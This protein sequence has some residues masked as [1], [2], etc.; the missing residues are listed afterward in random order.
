MLNRIHTG[1]VL[2]VAVGA[3]RSPTVAQGTWVDAGSALAGTSGDPHLVGTGPLVENLGITLSLTN[4]KPGAKAAMFV[5]VGS[6]PVAFHGGVLLAFPALVQVPIDVPGTGALALPATW[7]AGLPAGLELCFQYI[8]KDPAAV[9]GFALSNAVRAVTKGP[10]DKFLYVSG[11]YQ[12]DPDFGLNSNDPVQ[13]D[14]ATIASDVPGQITN[15]LAKVDSKT[16]HTLWAMHVWECG[17]TYGDA[18]NG[19]FTAVDPGTQDVYVSVHIGSATGSVVRFYDVTSASPVA[20]HATDN[21]EQCFLLKYSKDGVF[22]W[23]RWLRATPIANP[24]AASLV[25]ST[26]RNLVVLPGGNVVMAVDVRVNGGFNEPTTLMLGG[27]ANE[28]TVAGFLGTSA[29]GPFQSAVMEIDPSGAFVSAKRSEVLEPSGGCNS[30]TLIARETGSGLYVMHIQS[31]NSVRMGEG[32]AN[33]FVHLPLHPLFEGDVFFRPN[34]VKYDTTK[35]LQWCADT[36][37]LNGT[38]STDFNAA[39]A[40]LAVDGSG[41]VYQVGFRTD[42]TSPSY[43]RIESAG[44]VSPFAEVTLDPQPFEYR[45]FYAKHSASGVAQWIRGYGPS[46]IFG[47]GFESRPIGDVVVDDAGQPWITGL[48]RNGDTIILDE[49]LGSQVTLTAAAGDLPR[50]FVAR[51][52]PGDGTVASVVTFNATSAGDAVFNHGEMLNDG[53]GG[54]HTSGTFQMCQVVPARIAIG[55]D[56]IRKPLM[57]G[58]TTLTPA[59]NKGVTVLALM[60]TTGAVDVARQFPTGGQSVGTDVRII[61]VTPSKL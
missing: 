61:S 53:D 20:S 25:M 44:W 26:R 37:I 5:S 24:F 18:N 45:P 22:Q 31:D 35:E 51:L 40:G 23:L 8:I 33:E 28:E 42:P 29:G 34:L 4:A 54:K 48:L 60:Q 57:V 56:Y 39:P 38:K 1:L 12:S 13:F 7:P 27:G 16:L 55:L 2:L 41:D 21:V 15:W 9:H 52:N 58:A 11:K 30:A 17:A 43:V 46:S 47:G 50:V 3:M 36:R 49:G 14:A 10:D 59:V 6:V 19:P 32:E